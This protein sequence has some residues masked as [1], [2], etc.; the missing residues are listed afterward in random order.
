MSDS[1]PSKLPQD[2]LE[3]TGHGT[4]AIS[5]PANLSVENSLNEILVF[6]RNAQASDVHLSVNN[7]ILFRKF[8][9]LKPQ[10]EER[11]SAEHLEKLIKS[12]LTPEQLSDPKS[13]LPPAEEHRPRS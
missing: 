2:F 11:L 5:T 8:G 1:T 12:I 10:T 3:S 7:P 6:A 9:S 13:L 4:C